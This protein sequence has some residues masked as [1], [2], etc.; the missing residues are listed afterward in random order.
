MYNTKG[1]INLKKRSWMA[2]IKKSY[3]LKLT[4]NQQVTGSHPGAGNGSEP[5]WKR[6]IFCWSSRRDKTRFL[7]S[8]DLAYKEAFIGHRLLQKFFYDQSKCPI[9]FC[10]VKKLHH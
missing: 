2:K 10:L 9:K 5:V 4:N 7:S 3:Y 1:K 8:H 6:A